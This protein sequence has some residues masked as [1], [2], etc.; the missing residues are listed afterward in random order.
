[1]AGSVVTSRDEDVVVLSALQ[2]LVDGDRRSH[3]LLKV[4]VAV[5]LGNR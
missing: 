1:V 3:E 2:R 5:T 4:V